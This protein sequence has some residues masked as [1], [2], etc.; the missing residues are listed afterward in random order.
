MAIT[1]TLKLSEAL[2]SRIAMLAESAGKTQHAFMVEALEAEA[3][4]S[5]LRHDFV[6][7]ALK[8]EQE[9]AQYGEVYSM[10]AVHRYFSDKLAGKPTRK[11]KATKFVSASTS[12][13]APGRN[14]AAA[15]VKNKR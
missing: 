8:A 15:T 10:D 7:S 12:T 14:R 3:Q 1:T 9:V 13:P 4:R 2:K 11:L 5:E 6:D